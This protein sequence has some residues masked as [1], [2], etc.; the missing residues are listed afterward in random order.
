MILG[1]A[2]LLLAY[3]NLSKP[4]IIDLRHIQGQQCYCIAIVYANGGGQ[5]GLNLEHSFVF[6][7]ESTGL[8]QPYLLP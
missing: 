3:P 7:I 6:L 5:H 1:F 4:T 2:T 8:F